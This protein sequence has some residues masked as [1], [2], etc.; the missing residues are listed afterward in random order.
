MFKGVIFDFN[1]TLFEDYDL[2]VD[3]WNKVI[4]KYFERDLGPNEFRNCF[5]GLGNVDILNYL[6]SLEPSKQFDISI[7]DEKEVFYRELCMEHPERVHLISGAADTFDA[8]KNAG[9]RFAIGTASEILNVEFYYKFF[10][11]GRWF[12]PDLIIYDDRT[13]PNKPA[14]DIYLR[15]MD[16]LGLEPSECLICEDS[17]NGLIAAVRSGAGRVIA[18]KTENLLEDSC[19]NLNVYA[20]INDFTGFY[21]RYLE[22]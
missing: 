12:T 1:G 7:T 6:N 21:P 4:R 9:I 8:L 19:K 13:L 22:E 3:A 17:Q 20:I 11:L 15:A 18:R 2:Q 10:D 14:P 5:H 16:R